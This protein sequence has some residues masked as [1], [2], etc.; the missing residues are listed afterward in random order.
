MIIPVFLFAVIGANRLLQTSDSPEFAFGELGEY[1]CPAGYETI[2]RR[3]QCREAIAYAKIFGLEECGNEGIE[4]KDKKN[5][6]RKRG[7]CMGIDMTVDKPKLFVTKKKKFKSNSRLLCKN[8]MPPPTTTTAVPCLDLDAFPL[9]EGQFPDRRLSSTTQCEFVI[10]FLDAT[11]GQGMGCVFYGPACCS[12]C[13]TI[14]S[15]GFS[16]GYTSERRYW[17]LTVFMA[18][19]FL[20]QMDEYDTFLE[21]Q[22]YF[23]DNSVVTVPTVG[24]YQGPEN[25]I[26]YFLVQN[27][28]YTNFRHYIDPLVVADITLMD[29]SETVVEF[30]YKATAENFY[31]NGEPFSKL[32]A[33]FKATFTDGNDALIDNLTVEFLDRDVMAVANS[34][35]TNAELCQNIQSTCVGANAQFRNVNTCLAYMSTL[36]LTRK[37]C[38]ILKGPTRACRWMHMTL[39]QPALRPELHCA[40]AGPTMPDPNGAVKC[41]IAD[42]Y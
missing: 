12:T 4:C 13:A 25:I 39:A 37:D 38:P 29:A 3:S 24:V 1:S 16:L 30:Y 17:L 15:G 27:P 31:I 36:P 9:P 28:F 33:H 35:G 26:E 20:L 18:E 42:C 19:V 40:H 2:T 41:S 6:G 21:E 10:G 34:F 7:V 11:F 5:L 22:T 32:E 14:A 8:V 23:D